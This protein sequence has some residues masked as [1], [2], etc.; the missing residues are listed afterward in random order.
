MN[1]PKPVT[2]GARVRTAKGFT[3]T[4]VET[5]GTRARIQFDAPY[6]IASPPTWVAL[7][8]AEEWARQYE[9]AS[10]GS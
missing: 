2:V 8:T 1:D 9:V 7:E 10:C 5:K 4:V 6:G 3:G